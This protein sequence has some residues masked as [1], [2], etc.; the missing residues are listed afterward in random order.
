MLMSPD[1]QAAVRLQLQ[2]FADVGNNRIDA[3]TCIAAV[4]AVATG[5]AVP[6]S[7]PVE[8]TG[9][10]AAAALQLL[11]VHRE[12]LD[13]IEADLAEAARARGWTLE[14]LASA[15]GKGGKQAMGQHL[16]RLRKRADAIKSERPRARP[17][18]PIPALPTTPERSDRPA[19]AK[20]EIAAKIPSPEGTQKPA[21]Q[22]AAAPAVNAPAL[23][24]QVID[25]EDLV[26][27]V[28]AGASRVEPV[29]VDRTYRSRR[30]GA[31]AT[32]RGCGYTTRR[33]S[34]KM[35]L[36]QDNSVVWLEPDEEDGWLVERRHCTRC[37]PTG[38][39]R[40]I[41]CTACKAEGPL[42]TG[43]F[44]APGPV[45]GAVRAWLTRQQ[46][47]ETTSGEWMCPDH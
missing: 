30:S 40:S 9:A 34:E 41:Q 11:A 6:D 26:I 31:P 45:G 13:E 15:V 18:V 17:V 27:G 28:P 44:A 46:W 39:L 23:E 21:P 16:T 2:R 33:E 8:F 20:P 25:I 47:R 14:Q 4:H 24:G 36:Q 35:P 1:D 7:H 3:W 22:R 42:L 38:A 43:P 19:E 12:A 37:A 29:V 32:C 10:D 5:G